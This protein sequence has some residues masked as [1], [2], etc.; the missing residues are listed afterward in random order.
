MPCC[1]GLFADDD[2]AHV[3]VL[4]ACQGE[5][6]C[7]DRVGPDCHSA[8]QRRH[9]VGQQVEHPCTNELHTARVERHLAAVEIK[10][11]LLARGERKVAKLQGL[12]ANQ[13]LKGLSVVHRDT[14]TANGQVV[15]RARNVPR[16][17]SRFK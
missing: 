5:N 10:A 1:F 8:D 9:V 17:R 6:R 14:S 2:A 4:C 15:F 7:G 13:F 3:D 16:T 11:R 12:V